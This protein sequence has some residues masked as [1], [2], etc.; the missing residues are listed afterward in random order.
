MKTKTYFALI[1][2][3]GLAAGSLQA[4][5]TL[6]ATAT[7]TETGTAGSEFE[8]SLLLDNTG[9]NPINALWYGWIQF[10]FDLPS[11][12]TSITAPS[13]WTGT[14]DGKSIKFA[15]SSGSAIPSG[16][17]GT[18]TFESTSS[19]T[20]M[21]TGSNG[22]AP[23]GDSVAYGTVS[24]MSSSEENMAGVASA[25]FAP[26]LTATPEPSTLGLMVTGLAGMSAWLVKRRSGM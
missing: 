14:A 23:T 9:S 5:G 19:P 20:A 13:G 4:Q 2:T 17:F 18:F 26:T 15:N 12:P 10:A 16:G 3:A 8:Y 21:T 6:S 7:L 24:A 25:P 11:S 1:T 22:G